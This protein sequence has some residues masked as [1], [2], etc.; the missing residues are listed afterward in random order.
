[1]QFLGERTCCEGKNIREN[2]KVKEED[3]SVTMG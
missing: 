2:K 3:G 1:M